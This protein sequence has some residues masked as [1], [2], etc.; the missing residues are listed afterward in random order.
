M[1]TIFVTSMFAKIQRVEAFS[2]WS[3]DGSANGC[4][5]EKMTVEL[6]ADHG[7]D[8]PVGRHPL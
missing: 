6:L 5:G 7:A 8:L 4:A 2:E 1:G 3:D